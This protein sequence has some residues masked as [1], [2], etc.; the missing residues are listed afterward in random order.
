MTLEL[1]Q[2]LQVRFPGTIDGF[3][4][5]FTRTLLHSI[6]EA[7]GEKKIF[8]DHH[9]LDGYE[10]NYDRYLPGIGPALMHLSEQLKISTT[11]PDQG[12]LLAVRD[13][14]SQAKVFLAILDN[15]P[16]VEP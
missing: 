9:S 6:E 15:A 3:N 1:Q 4:E 10:T 13:L 16:P 5:R 8:V 2:K 11:M 7:L 14:I 12:T